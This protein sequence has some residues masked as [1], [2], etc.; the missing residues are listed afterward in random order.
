MLLEFCK[1]NSL[2]IVN[3]RVGKDKNIGRFTCRNASV[4]DYCISSPYL[5]KSFKDFDILDS[6]KLYSDVHSPITICFSSDN[7]SQSSK[8][9]YVDS[10][11][12]T[13][14]NII[15]TKRWDP[16][17][18]IHFQNN[19]DIEKMLELEHMLTLCGTEKD[20]IT[21]DTV[22]ILIENIC[23]IFVTSGQKPLELIM[24]RKKTRIILSKKKI[25]PG[26]I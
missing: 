19:I 20:M 10:R 6:S 26:L 3:G 1:G 9:E 13:V 22:D 25:N 14:E 15:K 7:F 17:K 12:H 4:V 5:L 23:N 16:Q 24:L 21:Q 11:N 18:Q 2:F 8:D